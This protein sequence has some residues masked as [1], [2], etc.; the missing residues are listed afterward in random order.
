[1]QQTYL[2]SARLSGAR[3]AF[4]QLSSAI[5]ID[6]GLRSID[7]HG[8]QF[9]G[10]VLT[11]ADMQDT[12]LDDADMRGALSLRPAQICSAKSRRGTLLDDTLQSQVDALCPNPH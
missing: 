3:L 12:N 4:A 10:T 8:A 7:F 11:N 9:Q 1:M 5:F 6:A 2:W